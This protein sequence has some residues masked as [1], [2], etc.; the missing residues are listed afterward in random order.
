MSRLS[1]AAIAAALEEDHTCKGCDRDRMDCDCMEVYED[2]D[3]TY[4][5]DSVFFA[6]EQHHVENYIPVDEYA[7]MGYLATDWE[8]D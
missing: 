2:G 5:P 6:F 7:D 4:D 1:N 3:S 8:R